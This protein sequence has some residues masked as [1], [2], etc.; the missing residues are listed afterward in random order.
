MNTSKLASGL[1]ILGSIKIFGIAYI[2]NHIQTYQKFI[3]T[4]SSVLKSGSTSNE[5]IL[6]SFNEIPS[7]SLAEASI[8][9]H[10]QTNHLLT[11]SAL[12]FAYALIMALG[13]SKS[14][15]PPKP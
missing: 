9:L 3:A 14:N 13:R 15:A 2:V 5:I 4:K 1:I 11:L 6:K 7:Q 12:V 8:Y 10:R